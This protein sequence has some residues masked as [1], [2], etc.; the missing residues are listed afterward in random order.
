MLNINKYKN[1]GLT[2]N[3]RINSKVGVEFLPEF[4]G[5]SFERSFIA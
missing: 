5:L 4:T 1:Q 3:Y 2:E